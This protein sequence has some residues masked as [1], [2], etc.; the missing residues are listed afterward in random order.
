MCGLIHPYS[1]PS[2]HA[3][4]SILTPLRFD[5]GDAEGPNPLPS[6]YIVKNNKSKNQQLTCHKTMSCSK[7]S[8]LRFGIRLR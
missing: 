3:W 6:Q 7:Q 2:L 4:L 8:V 1:I 5:L